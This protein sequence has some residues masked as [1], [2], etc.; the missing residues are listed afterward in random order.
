[1]GVSL[2]LHGCSHAEGSSVRQQL[3]L[4][5][6]PDFAE[7]PVALL[8]LL[9]IAPGMLFC[10]CDV[11]CSHAVLSLAV[12]PHLSSYSLPFALQLISFH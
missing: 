7:Q 3:V 8:V 1:M 6:Q 4:E 12:V 5:F 9:C 10:C 2:S 11:S